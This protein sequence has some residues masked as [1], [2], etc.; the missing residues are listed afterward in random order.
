MNELRQNWHLTEMKCGWKN[1]RENQR[2]YTRRAIAKI[3]QEAEEKIDAINA[4]T[5]ARI[6]EI[7][8]EKE[9]AILAERHKLQEALLLIAKREDKYMEEFRNYVATLPEADRIAFTERGGQL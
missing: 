3:E 9:V 2:D 8:A 6:K 5:K 1:E 7:N 4:E